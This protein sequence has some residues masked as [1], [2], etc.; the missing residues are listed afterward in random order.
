MNKLLKSLT[1][2][3]FF[4]LAL[5]TAGSGSAWSS[6]LIGLSLPMNARYE[7]VSRRIESGALLAQEKANNAGTTI[8]LKLVDDNCDAASATELAEQFSSTKAVIGLPCFKLAAA[9]ARTLKANNNN[10][11]LLT[12]RTR[13]SGLKRLREI[14]GLPIFEFSNKSNAEAQAIADFILPEFGSK[15]YAILDDG[16]VYGRGL[17]D[18]IRLIAEET[19]RKPVTNANFRPLQTN[20][21]ALI[22]RLQRSGVEAIIIAAA[23]EDVVTFANDLSALNLNW[24]VAMGEQISLLPFAAEANAISRP[25]LAV[26]PKMR[27]IS[28]Q[29]FLSEAAKANIPTDPEVVLGHVM[30]EVAAQLIKTPSAKTFATI[31]GSVS[32]ESDARIILEPFELIKWSN[33]RLSTSEGN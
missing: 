3:A 23:P 16:S 28:D 9:L 22:R 29:N 32:L 2:I 12:F 5:M 26:A 1:A 19:G 10:A 6:D 8:D 25:I 30:V 33:G 31:V 21:R 11:P 13:N 15:P 17:A 24:P 27:R 14:E 18:S 20:Q 7:A 4:P